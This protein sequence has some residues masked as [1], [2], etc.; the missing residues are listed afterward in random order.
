MAGKSNLIDVLR[1][2][3]RLASPPPGYLGLMHAL[4]GFGGFRELAWKGSPSADIVSISITGGEPEFSQNSRT[5][6]YGISFGGDPYGNPH[7]LDES[8]TVSTADGTHPLIGTAP[9]GRV[10]RNPDGRQFSI[11]SQDRSLLEFEIPDWQG[12]IVRQFFASCRFYSL[13]PSSMKAA[14]PTAAVPFLAEHG[15][16]LSAWLMTIQTTHPDAFAQITKAMKDL[17]P[18]VESIF[19]APTQQSTV[20]V[21]SKEKRMRSA[22]SG[23]FMSDGELVFLA[24]LSLMY[25]PAELGAAVYCIEE[26]ENHLHPRLLEVLVELQKQLCL[27][28]EERGQTF[29]TTHSPYLLDKCDLDELIVLERRDSETICTRPNSK[30]HL[31]ELLQNNEIGLG[32]LF[33][34]GALSSGPQ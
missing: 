34:S 18:Q 32:D 27:S 25:C 17:F 8:L 33:Y 7:L 16:N 12:T 10:L 19:A 4:A 11:I 31:L 21:A 1:F 29:V 28:G 5:W 15:E 23:G 9:N 22:I 13:L 14:N 26:P 6:N 20:L 24:L 3:N 2:V 30:P